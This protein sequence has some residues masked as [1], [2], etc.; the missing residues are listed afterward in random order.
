MCFQATPYH[1]G[2]RVEAQETN[3]DPT[4]RDQ[5]TDRIE[6]IPEQPIGAGGTEIHSP[7]THVRGGT[8][9]VRLT[10]PDGS[11]IGLLEGTA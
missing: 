4:G 9:M 2:V 7:F 3:P 1:V 10:D 5:G 8:S 6:G 11:P